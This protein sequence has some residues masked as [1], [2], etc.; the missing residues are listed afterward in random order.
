M[1]VRPKTFFLFFFLVPLCWYLQ[2]LYFCRV[3]SHT[4]DGSM[5]HGWLSK[6]V[7]HLKALNTSLLPP[8]QATFVAISSCGAR[9]TCIFLS[10]KVMSSLLEGLFGSELCSKYLNGFI[11]PGASLCFAMVNWF[12][13]VTPY[14]D[15]VC[16][17]P[18]LGLFNQET[19]QYRRT[20]QNRFCSSSIPSLVEAPK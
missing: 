18:L 19:K 14:G 17:C 5:N 12:V 1:L 10:C 4:L 2:P 13:L 9:T 3:G 6:F 7:M 16:A 8:S 20:V 15:G 11:A